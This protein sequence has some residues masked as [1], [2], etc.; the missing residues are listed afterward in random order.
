MKT[1][2]L[3]LMGAALLAAQPIDRTKPPQTPPLAAY[4]LPPVIERTLPN[5]L[6]VI[7]V[8]DK[9]FPLVSLR[10]DFQAGKKFDP[11]GL[12]GLSEMTAALLKEGTRKRS[13]RQIAE[14]LASIG[15]A[16]NGFAA[17]DGLGISGN[18]LSE[19]TSKLLE[20]LADLV[21]NAT[22]P[23]E[24]VNLRKQNRKQE[25]AAAR[26][27]AETIA[28]EK[29]FS[30]VYGKHPYS[31]ML[32]TDASIDKITRDALVG[33]RDQY[34]APNNAFLVLLGD[35]PAQADLQKLLNANFGDWAKK[36]IPKPAAVPIPPA[37]RQ[38]VLVDRPG[39][40]QADIRVGR[41]AVN[42]SNP[43]YFPLLLGSGVLGTGSSSRLFL[44]VREE[45]GWAYDVHTEIQPHREGG[46]FEVETQVRNEVVEPAVDELL[47][48]LRQMGAAPVSASELSTIKN[49][50]SGVFVISLETQGGLL[51]QLSGVRSE[52]LPT[53]YLEKY[54][55][56]I[57]AVDPAQIEAVARKYLVPDQDTIVVV[58][59]AAQIGKALEKTG[60]FIVEKSPQ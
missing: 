2:A 56:R 13:S 38:L 49:F 16:L 41:V 19:H 21:R 57:Q 34:L 4:K 9:R 51:G 37:K 23:Q 44:T 33:F 1:A 22:F 25:L 53:E 45:K 46:I 12:E 11:A 48:Q 60:K 7:L 20:L 24:E 8:E 39:S 59:D 58:G 30:V 52:G 28:D 29:F 5:G 40:V 6:T 3:L 31:R 43:D 10:M 32:P 35:L 27:Q 36:E 50:L 15:G 14:E 47:K 55:T 18:A 42:R 26:A 54:V 17:S